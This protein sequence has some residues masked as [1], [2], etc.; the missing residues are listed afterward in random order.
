MILE[1]AILFQ[2]GDAGVRSILDVM[3]R[4]MSN[5]VGGVGRGSLAL[6]ACL[7]TVLLTVAHADDSDA[8]VG[9]WV[10]ADNDGYIE[11]AR[12]GDIYEGTIVGGADED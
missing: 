8:I 12:T 6:T 4:L 5:S 3:Y 2:G 11:I 7:A 1:A 10:T 9:L